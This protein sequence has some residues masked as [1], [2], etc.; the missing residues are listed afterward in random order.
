MLHFQ[1]HDNIFIH[2]HTCNG[3]KAAQYRS[4]WT[5]NVSI[6]HNCE[7]GKLFPKGVATP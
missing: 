6:N 7:S 2:E 3:N 1:S 4:K 5:L